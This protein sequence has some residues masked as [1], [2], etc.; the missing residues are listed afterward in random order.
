MSRWKMSHFVP[1]CHTFPGLEP[2]AIIPPRLAALRQMIPEYFRELAK[3]ALR[4]DYRRARLALRRL[5]LMPRRIPCTTNILGP[6][7]E[8]VDAATFFPMYEEIFVRQIYKFQARGPRPRIIDG[9]ANIGLAT[10]YWKRAYPDSRITAFEADPAIASTLRRNVLSFGATDVEVVPCALWTSSGAGRFLADGADSGRLDLDAGAAASAQVAT[11]RLRDYLEDPV[12]LLKLD[13]EGAETQLLRDCAD[14]L[15]RVKRI[16][17]ECHSFADRPQTL[18]ELLAIL[19]SAGFR[20][21]L[22]NSNDRS[23]SP[24]AERHQDRGMDLQVNVFGYR[25]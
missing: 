1:Q 22:Q 11:V 20:V 21:Y 9:G 3:M 8:V 25:E 18:A 2:K 14:R 16:F 15:S 17:V 10:I 7:L 24:L 6:P 4:P 5:A 13:V 23:P 19:Q 12:D